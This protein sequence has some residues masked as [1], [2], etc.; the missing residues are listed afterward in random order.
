MKEISTPFSLFDFFALLFPGAVGVI[1]IYMFINPALSLTRHNAV[2]SK[3]LLNNFTGDLAIVTGTVLVCYF[4]GL[5]LSALSE[6]LID[7]PVN[8][9]LGSHIS[10]DINHHNVKEAVKKKFG[11]DILIQSRR[12]TFLMVEATVGKEL[13]ETIANV[14]KF[15]ALAIMFQSL[16]LALLIILAAVING[17]VSKQLFAESI[18]WFLVIACLLLA[19]IALMLWS[20]RRYKRMWSQT[21]FMSFVA[22]VGFDKKKEGESGD[23]PTLD[24]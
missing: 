5:V 7:R 10:K 23:E 15:I 16:S 11:E 1:G 19:L 24:A 21:L 4:F 2:F 17:W 8:K 9:I 6:L 22:L 18:V 3:T 20:Y 14:K 12:R 13:P